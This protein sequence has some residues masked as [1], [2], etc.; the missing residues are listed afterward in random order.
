MTA[1]YPNIYAVSILSLC[2][3]ILFMAFFSSAN[4][5]AKALRDSGFKKVGF[6]SLAMLYL[7]FGLASLWTPH[8][9]KRVNAKKAMIIASLM[10]SLW[11]ISLAMTTAALKSETISSYLSYN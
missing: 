6:Y 10:Y 4:S 3:F 1:R 7:N 5:A 2:F 8:I 11:I 9:V